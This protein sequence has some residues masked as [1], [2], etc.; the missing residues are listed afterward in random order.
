MEAGDILTGA[1]ILLVAGTVWNDLRRSDR[2]TAA[3]KTYLTVACIFA[4]MGI[5]VKVFV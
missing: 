5:V 2:L 4:A 1:A 3:Q